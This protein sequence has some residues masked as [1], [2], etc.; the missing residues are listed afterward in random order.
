MN[1]IFVGAVVALALIVVGGLSAAA[2][3]T[4][5]DKAG[6]SASP[7]EKEKK[8]AA[9][10]GKAEK[11]DKSEKS[12]ETKPEKNADAVPLGLVKGLTLD[13]GSV[14]PK[15]SLA[16]LQKLLSEFRSKAG[17][18]NSAFRDLEQALESDA[19]KAEAEKARAEKA[20]KTN[21]SSRSKPA[22]APASPTKTRTD[23]AHEKFNKA[24]EPFEAARSK[25]ET[26]LKE[27]GKSLQFEAG[28]EGVPGKW[29]LPEKPQADTSLLYFWQKEVSGKKTRVEYG[30][31]LERLTSGSTGPTLRG[32]GGTTVT[33]F[34]NKEKEKEKK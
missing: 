15:E 1:K 11:A 3:E 13:S 29:N 31:T 14:L 12:E 23:I 8:P 32:S 24:N 34:A 2:K 27:K 7:K 16:E 19:K 9:K 28:E 21:T 5:K 17:P 30:V 22:S 10:G 26:F 4:P 6:A 20:K 25:L 33:W 18:Y